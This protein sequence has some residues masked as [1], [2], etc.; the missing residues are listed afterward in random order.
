M[1]ETELL[2]SADYLL[3]KFRE[4]VLAPI[5]ERFLELPAPEEESEGDEKAENSE[6]TEI[7]NGT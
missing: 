1:N 6:S 5:R 2:S 7:E 3:E 4:Y